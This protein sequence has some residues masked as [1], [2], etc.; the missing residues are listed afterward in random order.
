M[1]T[2][3]LKNGLVALILGSS[4]FSAAAASANGSAQTQQGSIEHTT[5][6]ASAKLVVKQPRATVRSWNGRRIT[7]VTPTP[8]NTR[9]PTRGLDPMNIQVSDVQPDSEL[10]LF[11]QKQSHDVELDGCTMN[12][13]SLKDAATKAAHYVPM[14]SFKATPPSSAQAHNELITDEKK[15][16]W[17]NSR[18]LIK[19]VTRD[20]QHIPH[21]TAIVEGVQDM[22]IM[23]YDA[24]SN[25]VVNEMVSGR[26][27]PSARAWIK[28]GNLF[29]SE[30]TH[31]VAQV[32]DG[33]KLV[34]S[35]DAKAAL[36]AKKQAEI[37]AEQGNAQQSKP[38][39]YNKIRLL[40]TE[41]QQLNAEAA[42]ERA[43]GQALVTDGQK[44]KVQVISA[45]A[46]PARAPTT[47][48]NVRVRGENLPGSIHT[49]STTSDDYDGYTKHEVEAL[50]LDHLETTVTFAPTTGSALRSTA[51]VKFQVPAHTEKPTFVLDGIKYYRV[52][53]T[54]FTRTNDPVPAT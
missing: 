37:V 42:S 26:F 41:I 49:A 5:V 8:V 44:I 35:G 30:P 17:P 38:V 43:Q 11:R 36:A 51:T 33:K 53:S 9:F 45:A 1:K 21:V 13:G 19:G 48:V 54:G 16:A 4:M 14:V 46:L 52:K 40:Q 22:R 25:T 2:S 24:A 6:A 15:V 39:D 23:P 18:V 7:V 27:L 29:V 10:E 31:N 34:T 3:I 12:C 20:G 50:A 28:A 32:A 47:T